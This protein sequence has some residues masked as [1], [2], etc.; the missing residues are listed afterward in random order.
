VY[1]AL[2][3]LIYKAVSAFVNTKFLPAHAM[4]VEGVDEYLPLIV[5]SAFYGSE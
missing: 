5:T 1:K 3:K 4:R 2:L